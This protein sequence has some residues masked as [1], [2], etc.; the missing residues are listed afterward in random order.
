MK[1]VH[2]VIAAVLVVLVFPL[3]GMALK[4]EN[5]QA[6]AEE[7]AIVDPWKQSEIDHAPPVIARGS[8]GRCAPGYQDHPVDPTQCVLPAVLEQRARYLQ[9]LAARRAARREAL[10]EN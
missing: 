9:E 1:T 7:P 4:S 3:I 2:W 8:D 6:L 5:R 10:E